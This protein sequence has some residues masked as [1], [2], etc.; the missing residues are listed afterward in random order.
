MYLIF[1]FIYIYSLY[2]FAMHCIAPAYVSYYALHCMPL[3]MHFPIH[4]IACPCICTFLCIT[5]HC[6]TYVLLHALHAP[7]YVLS[8]ALHCMPLHMCFYMH[9]MPLHMHFPMHCI[10][11][12]CILLVSHFPCIKEFLAPWQLK[13]I[14]LR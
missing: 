2:T 14:N 13:H 9:C 3:H 5:L 8:Y 10:A 6:P 1:T 11:C 12:P 4:C 7:A